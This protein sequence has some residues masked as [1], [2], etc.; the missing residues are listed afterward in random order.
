V[1]NNGE[2]QCGGSCQICPFGFLNDEMG[3]ERN[4]SGAIWVDDMQFL[5]HAL[6]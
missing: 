4:R 1:G 3:T 6:I 2:T 5:I